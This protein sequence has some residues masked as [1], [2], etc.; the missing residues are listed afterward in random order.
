MTQENQEIWPIKNTGSWGVNKPLKN[1]RYKAILARIKQIQA[2]VYKKPD[3]LEDRLMFIFEPIG[4][5]QT[6]EESC[7]ISI[8]VRPSNSPKSKM[9]KL[10]SSMCETGVIPESIRSNTLDYQTFAQD[11]IGKTFIVVSEL[12]KNGRY[13][14]ATS[15]SWSETQEPVT[16]K[17]DDSWVKEAEKHE[18]FDTM[19]DHRTTDYWY[20]ITT[21][22]KANLPKAQKLLEDNGGSEVKPHYWKVSKEI[23]HL[24]NYKTVMPVENDEIPW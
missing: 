8:S 7:Y 12:S 6:D 19:P 20:N 9:Y 13:N 18:S 4:I 17:S 5:K 16:L 23:E 1:G 24:K 2:P 15:V 14:N 22:P 3:E 21:C 10:L 11:M